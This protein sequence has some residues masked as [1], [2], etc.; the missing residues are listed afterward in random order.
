MFRLSSPSGAI[1]IDEFA[2][3]TIVDLA[4]SSQQQNYS[5]S[6]HRVGS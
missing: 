6:S 4:V 5:E 3:G 2:I 1:L